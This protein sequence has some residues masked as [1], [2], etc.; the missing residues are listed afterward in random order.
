MPKRPK[1]P[2]VKPAIPA[3]TAAISLPSPQLNALTEEQAIVANAY[4]MQME[5]V[6][7]D[8]LDPAG[9]EVSSEALL[10][11]MNATVFVAYRRK[12]VDEE[13]HEAL[14]RCT[15][16]HAIIAKLEDSALYKMRLNELGQE[17]PNIVETQTQLIAEITAIRRAAMHVL[18]LSIQCPRE[19]KALS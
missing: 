3:S 17:T 1:Y 9:G 14:K 4:L 13:F 19:G 5:G 2:K 6:L 8:A 15:K 7:H 11:M 10:D 16:I 18:E 12:Y